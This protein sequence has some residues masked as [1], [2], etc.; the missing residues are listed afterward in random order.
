MQNRIKEALLK[1][2]M[3]QKELA[4]RVGMTEMGISKAINGSATKATI[5]KVATALGVDP[6][7]LVA[8]QRVY[9]AKYSAE[10]TPLKLGAL[11]IPCYVLDNGMRVF[12]GRGIQ[13]VLGSTSSSGAWL[14]RFIHDDSLNEYFGAGE[15][16][17]IGRIE[18]PISFARNNAGGSQSTTNGYEV[19]ILVDICSS[20][21]DAN[22]AG[23][24][25]DARIVRNADIIIRS[26]AKVGIIALVDEAT[27]YN[28]DIDRAKD[29]LQRFL[30]QFLRDEAAK[31]VKTFPD[32]FFEDIYK[33]HKWNWNQTYK[34]PGIVGTWIREIVYDRIAPILPKLEELNPKNVKGYR[35]H[36]HHQF[37]DRDIA[38]PKLKE[39]LEAI[40]AIAVISN[41]D[42]NR[43]LIN[44]EKAYPRKYSQLL[45]DFD[46]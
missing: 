3:T 41:F 5:D 32:Q 43:F 23:I 10:K 44:M 6:N 7:S 12:S 11:E 20:I 1:A 25:D 33:M 35:P 37:L 4:E 38:L 8:E 14:S 40:H 31:W 42:W 13:R 39:M 30:K 29:E 15:N 19:T 34:H 36:R 46:E 17:I 26:V 28:K 22:R 18:N 16:S 21:I 24:F 45:L 2:N 27:G 9:Y